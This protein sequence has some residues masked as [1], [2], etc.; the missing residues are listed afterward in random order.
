MTVTIPGPPF[1]GAKDIHEAKQRFKAAWRAFKE[2]QGPEA[3]AK[4]YA[5]M[6]HADRPDRYGR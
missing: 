1:G 2:R 4:A 3:L 5:D 6:N